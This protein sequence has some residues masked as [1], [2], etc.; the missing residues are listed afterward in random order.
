MLISGPS[1]PIQAVWGH[2][3]GPL[4][5]SRGAEDY[6]GVFWAYTGGL[7]VYLKAF[8]PAYPEGPRGYPEGPKALL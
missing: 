5:L 1:E 4:G 2:I 6:F 7:G 8:G 3:M